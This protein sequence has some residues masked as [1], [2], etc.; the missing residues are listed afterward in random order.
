MKVQRA[1]QTRMRINPVLFLLATFL[2]AGA[3]LGADLAWDTD[4]GTS[5]A[6][7]GD[8]TWNTSISTWWDGSANVSW[9][10][11]TPDVAEFY[12]GPGTV[13]LGESIT[14]Q[15]L[16][17]YDPDYTIAGTDTLTINAGGIENEGGGSTM[18]FDVPLHLAADQTWQHR[19]GN[20]WR[21]K[22]P[23]SGPGKIS[24]DG[25][26]ANPT[27]ILEADNSGWSGGLDANH[28]LHIGHDNALGT[29]QLDISGTVQAINGG[30][31]VANSV[32][33]WV[34][35]SD[36]TITLGGSE[37]LEFA[38]DFTIDAG[39]NPHH[40]DFNVTNTADTEFSGVIH[41]DAGD[42]WARD[43]RKTGSGQLIFSGD[44]TYDGTTWVQEGTL[45]VNGTPSTGDGYMV[46]G[47]GSAARLE[48]NGTINLAAGSSLT[49]DADGTLAPGESVG[50][51]SVADGD[52][53]FSADSTFDI[54]V[55][56]IATGGIDYDQLVVSGGSVILDGA[57]GLTVTGSDSAAIGDALTLIDNQGGA[58]TT[59]S[60]AGL[61]DDSFIGTFYGQ[62]WNI[63]YDAITGGALDG[64]NDVA[65]Y[66]T[67]EPGGLLAL[68]AL[69]ACLGVRRRN[70]VSA[71]R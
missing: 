14:A 52:L 40:L 48:G 3:V 11:S 30:H 4:S 38:G 58:T 45:V 19:A 59:G 6:Q 54:E 61:P 43:V 15:K 44:N 37:R 5:G 69:L 36:A 27:L 35:N 23:L 33:K 64:G 18:T 71:N 24:T 62:D 28:V 22:K 21:V 9:N 1:M 50:Q 46:G 20:D 8:G 31:T 55:S 34:P 42:T 51:L 57:L 12:D 39:I 41:Q 13:T 17:F 47:A 7:G 70:V 56:G 63:T 32:Y 65:L 68:L 66:A 49:I 10:N 26:G 67:P 29:G 25:G 53:I 60:F 2:L 16:W